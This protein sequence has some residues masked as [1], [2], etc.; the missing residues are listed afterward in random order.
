MPKIMLA[1]DD[2]TMLSLL[3]TLLSLE[4]L[5]SVTLSEDED[6][7]KAIRREDP[8]VILMDVHL[9]QGNGIDF[10]KLIRAEADMAGI[11]V[12]MQ[13]GMNLSDECL[14]AGANSFLLKP[15]MPNLLIDTIKSGL[16]AI[17]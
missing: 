12:I 10:L 8:K 1:E 5:A 6:P 14:A 13:S 7:I 17:S 16:G 3:K 15:Y 4:G 9:T 2:P 11:Y